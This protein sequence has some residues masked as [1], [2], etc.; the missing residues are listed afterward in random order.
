MS[1]SARKAIQALREELAARDAELL[2]IAQRAAA[3]KSVTPAVLAKAAGELEGRMR[4]EK[5]AEESQFRE[6][7]RHQ[8]ATTTGFQRARAEAALESLDRP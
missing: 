3:A 5:A 7:L 4:L 1:K 2:G 8:A 6:Y